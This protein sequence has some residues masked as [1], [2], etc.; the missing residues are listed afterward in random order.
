[1]KPASPFFEI[2]RLKDVCKNLSKYDRTNWMKISTKWIYLHVNLQC[3]LLSFLG[4][5]CPKISDWNMIA[6][7]FFKQR[8]ISLQY[9]DISKRK[10]YICYLHFHE[11][12]YLVTEGAL[13]P[14]KWHF[15][16]FKKSDSYHIAVRLF[17][18]SNI[19]KKDN[20]VP[21]HVCQSD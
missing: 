19:S 11:L 1:M 12:Q 3:T 16:L 7:R 14:E 17:S 20:N 2:K 21:V 5:C 4:Y 15:S 10:Q 8:K 13:A 9:I 18:D 6:V